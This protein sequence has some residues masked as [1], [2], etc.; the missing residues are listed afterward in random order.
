MQSRNVIVIAAIVVVV[1]AGYY[2][3]MAGSAQ[4]G[5]AP[6]VQSPPATPATE[7]GAAVKDSAP[8]SDPT[9][10]GY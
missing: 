3:L 2:W 6:T 10:G 1:A 5:S 4:Q 7:P 8:A 9:K